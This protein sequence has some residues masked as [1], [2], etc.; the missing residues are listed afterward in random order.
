MKRGKL[1]CVEDTVDRRVEADTIQLKFSWF[2]RY[3]GGDFDI[4]ASDRLVVVIAILG[5]VQVNIGV[6]TT[7]LVWIEFESTLQSTQKH[8]TPGPWPRYLLVGVSHHIVGRV[9]R[10]MVVLHRIEYHRASG[11]MRRTTYQV[12][13]ARCKN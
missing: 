2:Q 12:P 11:V 13:G 3:F 6:Q 9:H 4:F 7:F 5:F 10:E 8:Q 1:R